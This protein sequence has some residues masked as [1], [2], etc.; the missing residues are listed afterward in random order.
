MEDVLIMKSPLVASV[1][2][3]DPAFTT[4]TQLGL[5]GVN[6]ALKYAA[7]LDGRLPSGV[8]AGLIEDL[9]S[10][11]IVV[12][13]AKQ[14]RD[15]AKTAT[16][17]QDALAEKG[18]ELIR[19]VRAAVR[20]AR[21]SKE[22]QKAYTVGQDIRDNVVKDVV[23]GLQ[24]IIERASAMPSEAASVGIL[25]KDVAAMV[26]ARDAL[27]GADKVQEQK[28]ASAPLTTKERN[29]VANRV[30]AAVAWISGAGI[31]EF[32]AAPETRALFEELK[33]TRKGKKA[34][35]AVNA[36]GAQPPI[37]PPVA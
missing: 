13:G 26:A 33:V 23:A 16:A 35:P 3:P 32:A 21:A 7:A 12:P 34:K 19:A 10:M 24:Q 20:K 4:I 37:A 22:V 15:E 1:A 2:R 9:D 5:K 6:L 18:Y 28:R 30:L 36:G 17:T 8:V 11:G 29:I 31:L 27:T 14:A 25:A